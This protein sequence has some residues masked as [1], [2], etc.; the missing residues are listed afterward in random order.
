M[1]IKNETMRVL[2]TNGLFQCH[3]CS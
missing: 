2:S 1:R 3:I